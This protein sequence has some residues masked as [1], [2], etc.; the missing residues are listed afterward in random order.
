[1]WINNISHSCTWFTRSYIFNIK[2]TVNNESSLCKGRSASISLKRL[3]WV[4]L[5]WSTLN[6]DLFFNKIQSWLSCWLS[7]CWGDSGG[8]VAGRGAGCVPPSWTAT[9]SP[10]WGRLSPGPEA[11]PAVS[12]SV[13]LWCRPS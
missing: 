3:V 12:A 8:V 5:F 9:W 13:S 2:S 4:S 10:P 1:M 7:S 6:I 11:A